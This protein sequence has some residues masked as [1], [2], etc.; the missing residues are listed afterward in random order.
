M[1][2][3]SKIWVNFSIRRGFGI[4]VTIYVWMYVHMYGWIFAWMPACGPMATSC[5]S[6]FPSSITFMPL[7]K[8]VEHICVSLLLGSLY[9][10]IQICVSGFDAT[11]FWLLQLYYSSKYQNHS[12]ISPKF[13]YPRVYAFSLYI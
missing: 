1:R 6:T 9:I 11:L 3:D 13:I 10:S 4:K 7:S 8:L 2:A 5:S 12:F